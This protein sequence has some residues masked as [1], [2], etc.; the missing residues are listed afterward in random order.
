MNDRLEA[1]EYTGGWG[2][3]P[4]PVLEGLGRFSAGIRRTNRLTWKAG[5]PGLR[6]EGTAG[7][8]ASQ[9]L[10]RKES[11]EPKAVAGGLHSGA[12]EPE[13][14]VYRLAFQIEHSGHS[15]EAGWGV[16][17]GAVGR[18][19]GYKV[20]LLLLC[21]SRLPPLPPHRAYMGTM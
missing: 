12:S 8:L 18:P 13:R 21:S 11:E 14:N 7:P 19:C 1:C 4:E 3:P 17:K 15:A 6:V 2:S 5:Q 16:R 20:M 9:G 10:C